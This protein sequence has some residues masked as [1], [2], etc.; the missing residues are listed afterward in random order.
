MIYEDRKTSSLEKK[1]KKTAGKTFPPSAVEASILQT[2]PYE[3][4]QRKITVN[5]STSEFSC[6]CPFSGLPDFATLTIIYTPRKKIVELKSLKYYLYAF[7]SVRIYNEHLVN[8]VLEDLKKILQ[9]YEIIVI[10][11]FTPRG[12]I[13]NKVV[14]SYPQSLKDKF[15]SC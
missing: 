7:R 1:A 2:I 6:L 9:P 14:A 13:K 10:G 4:P 15:F 12:G 11:E 8:K 3:Y 5:L